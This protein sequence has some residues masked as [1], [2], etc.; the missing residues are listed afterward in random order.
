MDP[1][2]A[3]DK[4]IEATKLSISAPRIE[5]LAD[6]NRIV[7]TASA[8][9]VRSNSDFFLATNW[10]CLAG[11][12]PSNGQFLS[13]HQNIPETVRV[14]GR[15][16]ANA[17]WNVPH[18]FE[19]SLRDDAANR[20]NW[21]EHPT[22]GR[23][24]DVGVIPI[25]MEYSDGLVGC[26]EDIITHP[27]VKCPGDEIFVLGYPYNLSGGLNYPLWKRGSIASEPSED[28]D[29]LPKYFIDV[30]G[31]RGMSGAPVFFRS[32]V[33]LTENSKLAVGQTAQLFYGLYSGRI[34]EKG[35]DPI[36]PIAAQIG[37][38]WK[39]SVIYETVMSGVAPR[40]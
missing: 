34:T 27:I 25:P 17:I 13:G 19:I 38:V 21:L 37:I 10:H 3:F 16:M 29:N 2:T 31:R 26:N 1:V 15:R 8:A 24:V 9:F 30:A 6:G 23:A 20:L 39:P 36:D 33:H 40:I 14:I 4:S 35:D 28:I 7:A 11:I 32:H 5:L 18:T 12:N 22:F